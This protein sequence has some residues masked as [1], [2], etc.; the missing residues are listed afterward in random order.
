MK[1][2]ITGLGNPG[3]QYAH[4]RH[5]IGFDVLDTLAEV[6]NI[7]FQDKRYGY[8]SEFK[9]KARTFHLLKPST[10][11]NLSG[12]AVNYYLNKLKIYPDHLLVI[13]D[14]IALPFGKLRI[15]PRGGDAG[16]NG[17]SSIIQVLGTQNFPRLRFGIGNNFP[18][19]GQINYVLGH[20]TKEEKLALPERIDKACEVIK[21]FGTIGLDHTMNTYNNR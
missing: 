4:T 3:E 2:L 1:Y 15:R 14:D 17:M 13:A 9:F 6:S 19:G 20:W 5:N 18:P 12:R 11:V 21:A 16:H 8:I 7:S 10:Y